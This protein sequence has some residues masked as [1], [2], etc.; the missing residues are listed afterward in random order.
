[1]TSRTTAMVAS[2]AVF[3]LARSLWLVSLLMVTRDGRPRSAYTIL[4]RWDGQWYARIAT[5]GYGHSWLAPDGGRRYDYAFFP[6]LPLLERAGH[7]LT[8][9]APAN[10]GLVVSWTAGALAAAGICALG[11]ELHSP[12]VGFVA[13]C[14]WSILPMSAVLALSY[15]DTLLAALAAWGLVALQRENWVTAG[16]LAAA[17]GFTR[18]TGAALVLTVA[19]AAVVAATQQRRWRPMLAAVLA[20]TGLLGYLAWVSAQTGSATGYFDVTDGWHNGF[21]GGLSFVRWIGTLGPLAIA[22]IAAVAT[23]IGLWL[24]LIRDH[25]PWPVILYTAVVITMALTT[26]GY[27]GSKP[28]YLLAAFPLLLPVATRLTRRSQPLVAGV[29]IALGLIGTTYG[30]W[31]LTGAGP[32]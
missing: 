4:T 17:A 24:L 32:P 16:L 3:L 2:A 11:T 18:P 23:L 10:V 29:L 5:S 30:V 8:G 13:A 20:P 28:R 14:L 6:L 1:M 15:S 19:A 25:E 9:L 31:W 7:A 12:R 22:V 21:D 26:S 27:F